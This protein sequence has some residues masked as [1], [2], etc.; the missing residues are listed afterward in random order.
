MLSCRSHRTN[1]TDRTCGQNK[2]PGPGKEPPQ[3]FTFLLADAIC[4][5]G[6]GLC[7]MKSSEMTESAK[8]QKGRRAKTPEELAEA[9]WAIMKV[10][11]AQQSCTAGAVQ[12]AL[13]GS[14]LVLPPPLGQGRGIE[15]LASQQGS[16]LAGAGAPLGLFDDAGLAGGGEAATFG[17]GQDLRVG[18]GR[19]GRAVV[20]PCIRLASLR[21]N[22]PWFRVLSMASSVGIISLPSTLII[23]KELSHAV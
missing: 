19:F 17:P 18:D 12:E 13:E 9:E 7:R 16:G 15:A 8:Q 4:L 23:G 20:G 6:I 11:W 10:V 2:G 1:K 5:N 14:G 21:G 3:D 22:N